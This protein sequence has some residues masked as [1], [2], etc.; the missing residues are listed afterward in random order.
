M[1]AGIKDVLLIS[2]L[3]YLLNFALKRTVPFD[4]YSRKISYKSFFK[5]LKKILRVEGD[6]LQCVKI[7]DTI[8]KYFK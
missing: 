5:A 8:P 3:Q 4:V 7:P 6:G 2:I 1:L